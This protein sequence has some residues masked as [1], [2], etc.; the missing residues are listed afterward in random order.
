MVSYN[1]IRNTSGNYNYS[2]NIHSTNTVLLVVVYTMEGI[3][4]NTSITGSIRNCGTGWMWYGL[5]VVL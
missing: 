5:L 2:R 3:T 1:Y 4:F